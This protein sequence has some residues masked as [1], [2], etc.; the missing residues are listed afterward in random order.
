VFEPRWALL[1]LP[2]VVCATL[3]ACTNWDADA[4]DAN[5]HPGHFVTLSVAGL[6][7]QDV[8][9]FAEYETDVH[10]CKRLVDLRPYW[11]EVPIALT[12]ASNDIAKGSFATDRFSPGA[13]GWHFTRVAAAHAEEALQ[14]DVNSPFELSTIAL[15]RDSVESGGDP[16]GPL[17]LWCYRVTYQERL[18]RDCE[19]LAALHNL[20]APGEVSAKFFSS[21]AREN[22]RG[23]RVMTPKT[24][25]ISV[26]LRSLNAIPGAL[27]SEDERAAQV[28]RF[29]APK[30]LSGA[31]AA[32]VDCE[33]ASTAVERAICEDKTLR[34]L[35]G[36]FASEVNDPVLSVPLEQRV[37]FWFEE[38][39]WLAARDTK[40]YPVTIN[41]QT[42]QECL[43][44][45][46]REGIAALKKLKGTDAITGW[47]PINNTE[48]TGLLLIDVASLHSW[49]EGERYAYRV[50]LFPKPHTIDD[51]TKK[52]IL[53]EN[54]YD[55][56]NCL[57]GTASKVRLSMIYEDDTAK[58][59]YPW[60]MAAP[61]RSVTPN[62]V[63]SS[64]MK[65]V[66]A[67]EL[68]SE[69][70]AA[71]RETDE[72][73][74]GTWRIEGGAPGKIAGPIVVSREKIQLTF[75]DK[76]TCAVSYRLGARARASSFP[77]GPAVTDKPDDAYTTVVLKIG[78]QTASD[79][80]L[81]GSIHCRCHY[82]QV[83]RISLTSLH[84]TGT[85]TGLCVGSC[86]KTA[87]RSQTAASGHEA[88]F[89]VDRQLA[90]S[91]HSTGRRGVSS[92]SIQDGLWGLHR[93]R[94]V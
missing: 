2:G 37:D 78:P 88:T 57:D 35:D 21:F 13:C 69:S 66:C 15:L 44:A 25:D 33:K 93:S 16:E 59:Y 6:S 76:R 23:I 40:C 62:S 1:A 26:T 83:N 72:S 43:A 36:A 90:E 58:G 79:L 61:W 73:I 9:F 41:H 29:E 14:H 22:D 27:I 94:Q 47:I 70:P 52:P 89:A 3:V 91:G 87:P 34:Q 20:N 18:H 8:R 10:R 11:K 84:F 53:Y 64:E 71:E 38:R 80:C 82:R 19:P 63:L 24:T 55:R 77:G 31:N 45:F 60:G 4:P 50:R 42:L 75:K 65:F 12:L 17:D 49:K 67:V 28:A 54:M 81:G 46:Y 32:P 39:Q 86:R 48:N 92:R 68:A 56:F 74:L 5:P 85:D 30:P 51:K 7:V